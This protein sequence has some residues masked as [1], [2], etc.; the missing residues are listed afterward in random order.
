MKIDKEKLSNGLTIYFYE[1]HR[2]HSTFFQFVTLF[3]GASKDFKVDGIEYHF[4][5]GIAHILEHYVVEENE[6]GNF[7]RTLGERQMT[8]NAATYNDMT[9]FYFEAVEDLEYGIETLIKGIYSP[10]FEEARLKKVKEPIYQEIRGRSGNKFYHSN[11]VTLNNLLNEIKFRSIGGTLQEVE[12]T[13]LETLK[14]C[15]EAFYQPTNQFIVVGG[16]FDKESVLDLIKNVYKEINYT[17]HKVE[18]TELKEKKEVVKKYEDVIFP[19]GEEY[20]EVSYKIDVSKFTIKER[21]KLDFY[22]NCFYE[23]FFGVSSPLYNELVS[24]K[25]ITTSMACGDSQLDKFLLMSIGSYSNELKVLEKSIKDTIKEM[26]SFDEEL[27]DLWKK[28]TI[29]NVILREE[30]LLD[31]IMPFVFNVATFNYPYLDT[32]E[33]IEAFNFLEF[34][35]M[36]SS[37][38]FNNFTV[39]TIK[40]KKQLST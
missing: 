20:V 12:N 24:D 4:D 16:N 6:Y 32:K 5:D 38:D 39:T 10:V 35:E 37:L 19:T 31:V 34:K 15:Y 13:D 1:D 3:G 23:M 9:R 33:D 25:I 40:I 8:T 30:K 17:T 7:L 36:I 22:L 28:D 26:N 18:K 14:L 21:L 29:L 27:F 2:R 11:Q